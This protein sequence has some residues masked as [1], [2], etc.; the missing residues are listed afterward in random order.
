MKKCHILCLN[1][2]GALAALEI[3]FLAMLDSSKQNLE[4]VDVL[5]GV[6]AGALLAAAM[7]TGRSFGEI[8]TVFQ[9]RAKEC[10]TKRF[11][12]KINPLACPTYRSDTMEK[13]LN[14][15]IGANFT[16][17]DVKKIYPRLNVILPSLNV[18]DDIY[19]PFHNFTHEY[20]NKKLVDLAMASSAAPT[21]FEGRDMDGRCYIDAGLIEVDPLLTA[22]TMAKKYLGAPFLSQKVMMLGS[23]MD[24]DPS[25]MPPKKYNSLS[26]L[27][28]A[29]EILAEYATLSNKLFTKM[30]GNGLGLGYWNF[31]NP[32]EVE[33]KIDD[34]DQIPK[35]IELAD[36]H[37]AEFL[38]AWDEWLS[39]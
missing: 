30:C 19:C 25:P 2:G 17:R 23:G 20:D 12:A 13:V 29:T 39:K 1:G 33:G 10:F 36:Q 22:T 15:M 9:K 35:L 32:V 16:M 31:W 11:A 7:A 4:G 8:D 14:E 6:S 5:A 21:Y 26:L 18:S 24:R 38:A 27:S 3:H 28:V 37:R 34:T